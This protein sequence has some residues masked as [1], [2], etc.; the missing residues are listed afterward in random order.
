M[1]AVGTAPTHD[2]EKYAARICGC[3]VRGAQWCTQTNPDA[4]TRARTAPVCVNARNRVRAVAAD[5][6]QQRHRRAP[7]MPVAVDTRSRQDT[8]VGEYANVQKHP[9]CGSERIDEL[10]RA[11]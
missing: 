3:D 2:C 10:S 6:A 8:T 9:S 11:I 4:I 1:G 7:F 5:H